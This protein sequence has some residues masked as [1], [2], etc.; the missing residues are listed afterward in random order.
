M[1]LGINLYTTHFGP[2]ACD[3][4]VGVYVTNGHFGGG[5]LRNSQCN[6]GAW[7]AWTPQTN[8]ITLGPVTAKAGLMVGAI[9]GYTSEFILPLLVPS[10][11]AKLPGTPWLRASYLPKYGDKSTVDGVHFSIEYSF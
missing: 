8:T 9:S 10:V 4:T 5:L 7:G 3:T 6:V 1:D 11:A 2:A